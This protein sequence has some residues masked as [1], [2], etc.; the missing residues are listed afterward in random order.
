M[1]INYQIL[2]E[3]RLT[4]FRR[5]AKFNRYGFLAGGTALS[6]Q[7]NHRHSYDFDFFCAKPLGAGLLNLAKKTF[8]IRETITNTPDELSFIDAEGIKFSFI[9]Y[10]FKFS[11]KL[12]KT[13]EGPALLSIKNIAASKAYTIGRR[14]SYRDY[15][16]IYWLLKNKLI[17]M[18]ELIALCKKIYGGLWSEKMFLSQLN[19][20]GDISK[21][22]ANSVKFITKKISFGELKKFFDRLAAV[23]GDFVYRH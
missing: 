21:S 12:I 8:K 2:D 16:D 15:V 19:Y 13:K 3:K 22:D 23:G 5:L 7:I 9:F 4:A 17:S 20:F 10:P 14:G 6:L 11:G 18:R 1:A